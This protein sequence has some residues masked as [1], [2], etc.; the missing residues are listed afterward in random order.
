MKLLIQLSLMFTLLLGSCTIVQVDEE[1]LTSNDDDDAVTDGVDLGSESIPSDEDTFGQMLHN[2]SSKT[3][4][5]IEFSIEGMSAFLTC[6]L[7]DSITLSSDGTYLYDGGQD[8]CGAEDDIQIRT[9]SWSFDFATHELILEP[10]TENEAS[11]IVMTLND[12]VLT[13]T[14][15]YESD[16]FGDFDIE[17]RYS[18]N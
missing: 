9:G 15:V 13:F 8:L 14:G 1:T 11:A 3:W 18:S 4:S 2:N 16:V 7:D 5:A 10:G 6:R 12:D 17:G